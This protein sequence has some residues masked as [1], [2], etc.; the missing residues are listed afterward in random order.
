MA[1]IS[2]CPRGLDLSRPLATLRYVNDQASSMLVT[3]FHWAVFL[4]IGNWL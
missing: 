1:F 4:L 3:D 2:A